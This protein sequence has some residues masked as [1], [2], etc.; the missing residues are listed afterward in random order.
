MKP[1]TIKQ[2]DASDSLIRDPYMN[3]YGLMIAKFVRLDKSPLLPIRTDGDLKVFI[4]KRTYS[5]AI[6]V[7][8]M[9]DKFFKSLEFSLSMM[10][11][12]AIGGKAEY[13]KLIKGSIL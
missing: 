13:Y 9:N 1:L 2:F 6:A 11:S 5:L 4:N 10:A 3:S 7:D 12:G 8:E